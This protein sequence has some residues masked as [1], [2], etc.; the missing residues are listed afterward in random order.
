[1]KRD[2]DALSLRI[3]CIS[4][5]YMATLLPQLRHTQISAALGSVDDQIQPVAS[6]SSRNNNATYENL[7]GVGNLFPATLH[8]FKAKFNRFSN[9]C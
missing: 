4:H 9:V 8:V 2:R 5:A 1:M 7:A 6:D 3:G